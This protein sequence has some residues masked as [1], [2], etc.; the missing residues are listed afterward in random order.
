MELKSKIYFDLDGVFS[1]FFG[2]FA[3]TCGISSYKEYGQNFDIFIK[4][5]EKHIHGTDFFLNLPKFV[6][7]DYILQ[8]VKNN[9]GEFNILSSPLAGDEE[10]TAILKR[11]WCKNNLL[12][13]PKE[14]I[15]SKNKTDYSFGNILI[16]D[17]SPNLK[18]WVEAGGIAIKY[19]ANS[20]NYSAFDLVESLKYIKNDIL[21]NGFKAKEYFIHKDTDIKNNLNN[22]KS[23]QRL[24]SNTKNRDFGIEI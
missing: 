15:I 11:E 14:V 6:D 13:I 20:K 16:D 12:I 21:K 7:T 5:C 18:K 17:F 1:D 4:Y 10:N 23:H 22:I 2:E 8:E 19:K 24:T 9:F 3:K